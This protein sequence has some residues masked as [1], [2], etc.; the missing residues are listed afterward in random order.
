MRAA[1]SYESST[2][3]LQGTYQTLLPSGIGLNVINDNAR[4]HSSFSMESARRSMRSIFSSE[5]EADRQFHFRFEAI[6]EDYDQPMRRL[7]LHPN[8][9][10]PPANEPRRRISP[11]IISF[12]RWG[13]SSD[14]EIS[15]VQ[16]DM[17]CLDLPPRPTATR[18]AP[19]RPSRRISA[20]ADALS[21]LIA[22][23]QSS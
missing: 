5:T 18:D 20:D 2:T 11:E 13:G 3:S 17:D 12:D 8:A 14:S 22:S 10:F 7:Q 19:Q 16:D 1:D 21:A 6:C 23:M 4:T 15:Y 9:S